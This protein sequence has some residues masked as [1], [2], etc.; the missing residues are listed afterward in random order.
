MTIWYVT[1]TSD[2]IVGSGCFGYGIR[3][4]GVLVGASF[5]QV[6]PIKIVGYLSECPVFK[7][8]LSDSLT[9]MYGFVCNDYNLQLNL[10]IMLCGKLILLF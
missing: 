5:P 2:R 3:F 7:F 4:R 10:F 6:M 9:N 8:P 1:I